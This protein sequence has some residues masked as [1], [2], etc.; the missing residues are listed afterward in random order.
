MVYVD[1][2]LA[3]QMRVAVNE[4][5]LWKFL[6]QNYDYEFYIKLPVLRITEKFEDYLNRVDLLTVSEIKIHLIL[7]KLIAETINEK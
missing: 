4:N 3:S 6:G 2:A 7:R 1:C 5:F